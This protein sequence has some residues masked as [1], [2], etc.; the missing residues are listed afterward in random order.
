MQ[1]TRGVGETIPRAC[2][3]CALKIG[4]A[5]NQGTMRGNFA[6]LRR[7]RAA[8]A[9][10]AQ[11]LRIGYSMM[12]ELSRELRL[13]PSAD[14]RDQTR[15]E[16]A[17]VGRELPI[18]VGC[19]TRTTTTTTTTMRT[20]TT[21]SR[22]RLRVTARRR[23][24]RARRGPI[25]RRQRRQRVWQQSLRETMCGL[26]EAA[27]SAESLGSIEVQ[28][29]QLRSELYQVHAVRAAARRVAAAGLVDGTPPFVP[30]SR[31][32]L[33]FDRKPT[34]STRALGAAAALLQ[35]G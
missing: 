7:A 21:M 20:T 28:I 4:N 34:R 16:Q 3:G 14:E 22:A 6:G 31:G 13:E 1:W 27:V 8:D 25:T 10:L 19:A 2:S 35:G 9:R 17:R 15:F 26:S 30:S 23:A 24:R 32:K 18:H 11:V 33:L 12:R 29:G 5:L